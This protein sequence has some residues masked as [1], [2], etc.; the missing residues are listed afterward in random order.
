MNEARTLLAIGAKLSRRGA[1]MEE[2]IEYTNRACAE[3]PSQPASKGID[4]T[5]DHIELYM[6]TEMRGCTWEDMKVKQT[7]LYI[8]WVNRVNVEKDAA[9]FH[10]MV[11]T[12]W[13]NMLMSLP[14]AY[15]EPEPYVHR[16]QC[17]PPIVTF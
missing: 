9:S 3:H 2:V 5:R 4:V 15:I 11:D 1:T 6:A 13:L 16:P 17:Y 8:D 14:P 12:I 10:E 7:Y